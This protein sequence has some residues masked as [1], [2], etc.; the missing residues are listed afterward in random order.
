MPPKFTKPLENTI[1]IYGEEVKLVWAVKSA[2]VSSFKWLKDGRVLDNP[3]NEKNSS[4]L[5]LSNV[6]YSSDGQYEVVATNEVGEAKCSCSL[7]VYG[8][9]SS[10]GQNRIYMRLYNI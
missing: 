4:S 3:E 6:S 7:N 8:M 1:C 5:T 9:L 10:I 2:P